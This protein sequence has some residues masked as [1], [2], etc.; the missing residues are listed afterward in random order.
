MTSVSDALKTN[1]IV[2]ADWLRD[3]HSDVVIVDAR[4]YLDG[5]EGRDAHAKSHIASVSY[6]HLTLPT[7]A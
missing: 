1:P 7:K 5:R 4:A 2:S 3:N 6:T